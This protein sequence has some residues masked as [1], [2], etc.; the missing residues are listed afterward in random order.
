MQIL[1]NR[2]MIV[3]KP[4]EPFLEWFNK[5]NPEREMTLQDMRDDSTA[6][7]IPGFETLVQSSRYVR[8]NYA[9][10]LEHILDEWEPDRDKWPQ[11]TKYE[12]FKEWFD[13]YYH[14]TIIDT[15]EETIERESLLY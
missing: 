12:L 4:R 7:L 2:H 9:E 5:L 6:F 11:D 8:E 1:R 13:I 14:S 10:F 3:A 15:C